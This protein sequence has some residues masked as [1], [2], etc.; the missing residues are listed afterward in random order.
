MVKVDMIVKNRR[1]EIVLNKIKKLKVH[2]IQN[3]KSIEISGNLLLV[4]DNFEIQWF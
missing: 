1:K 2:V 4:T 3:K